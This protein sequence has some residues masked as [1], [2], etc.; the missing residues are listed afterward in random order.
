M[1]AEVRD[2]ELVSIL[3]TKPKSTPCP[4][5]RL[6]GSCLTWT[7]KTNEWRIEEKE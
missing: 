4:E 5:G 1:K 7:K 2:E 3:K 6:H